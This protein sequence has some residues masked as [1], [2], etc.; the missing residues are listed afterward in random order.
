MGLFAWAGKK[1]PFF[2][3]FIALMILVGR[4]E[5]TATGQTLTITVGAYENYPLICTCE[6]E[7]RGIYADILNYVAEEED[8]EIIWEKDT[9]NNNLEK[10]ENEEIDIMPA[11]AFSSERELLYYF[12]NETVHGNYGKIFQQV[13]SSF[14]SFVDLEGKTIAVLVNDIFYEGEYGIKHL[15]EQFEVEATYLEV[16]AY[17]E[18]LEAIESE[19]ADAGVINRLFTDKIREYKVK[20]SPLIFSPIELRFAFPKGVAQNSLLID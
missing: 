2:M 18:V 16:N 14:E 4:P 13:D 8:W 9:W 10:L 12:N 11:I 7:I 15:L 1:K 19:E 20:E 17:S 5:N 6:E 3:L